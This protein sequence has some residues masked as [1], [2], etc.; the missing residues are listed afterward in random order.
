MY[1]IVV[2]YIFF[3]KRIGLSALVTIS[4]G[5]LNVLLVSLLIGGGPNDMGCIQYTFHP[6]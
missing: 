6:E 2:K 4:S 3:S 5:L 1:L